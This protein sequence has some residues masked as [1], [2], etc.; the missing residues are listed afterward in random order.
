MDQ[1]SHSSILLAKHHFSELIS[2]A[3]QRA[4]NE[5]CGIIAGEGYSSKKIYEVTNALHSPFEYLMDPEE[6]VRVFWE[7]ENHSWDALAFFH[8]HPAS[9][10][11]PSPTDLEKNF[12]PDTPYLIVGR[13]GKNW[14]VRG[15]FLGRTDFQE[16]RV[17]I[18]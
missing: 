3:K 13:E 16:I 2:I 8:S 15:F 11:I 14:I 7:M 5:A 9:P 18:R 12:Y 17:I 1:L 4:P 6:M 10:P